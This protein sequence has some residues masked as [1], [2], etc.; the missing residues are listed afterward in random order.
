VTAI[1]AAEAHDVVLGYHRHTAVASSS[2]EIP[3]RAVTAI[4]GPNGSGKSTVL[5]ALAGLATPLA[6]TLEVL[7]TTW[8]PGTA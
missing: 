6:G 5:N 7:E 2:F 3:H 4:I 8:L 1:P